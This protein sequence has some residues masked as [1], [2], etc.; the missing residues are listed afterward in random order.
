MPKGAVCKTIGDFE[1]GQGPNNLADPITPDQSQH[2][3][4]DWI[5]HA[6]PQGCPA[7]F[8]SSF[9]LDV[10]LINNLSPFVE[11]R[12]DVGRE[13]L[14]RAG[15]RIVAK[16]RQAFLDIWVRNGGGEPALQQIDDLSGR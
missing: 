8:T 4:G 11:L 14:G 10:S 13:F 15:D 16:D 2:L 9:N 12:P 3:F 6:L 7:P 1:F 5:K